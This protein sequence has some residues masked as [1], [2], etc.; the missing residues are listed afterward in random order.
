MTKDLEEILDLGTKLRHRVYEQAR[1]L[2]H[3]ARAH[4]A[5]VKYLD[6]ITDAERE[7]RLALSTTHEGRKREQT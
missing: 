5:Y 6:L 3:E 2:H 1:D 7:L 4:D